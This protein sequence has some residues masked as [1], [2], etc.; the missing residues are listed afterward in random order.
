MAS[1]CFI[2]T[3]SVTTKWRA[4]ELSV[5]GGAT[6]NNP[7]RKCAYIVRFS[8]RKDTYHRVSFVNLGFATLRCRW[9]KRSKTHL[10]NGGLYTLVKGKKITSKQIQG[11]LTSCAKWN[12]ILLWLW[13]TKNS[14]LQVMWGI[15]PSVWFSN[16]TWLHRRMFFLMVLTW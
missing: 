14:F 1:W 3:K 15:W 13:A 12:W 16:L 4:G 5:G 9:K 8:S 6:K 10:P 2:S 7:N 11:W